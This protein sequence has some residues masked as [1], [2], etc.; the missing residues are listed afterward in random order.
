M[1]D[2]EML[3]IFIMIIALVLSAM[4]LNNNNKQSTSRHPAATVRRLASQ[5]EVEALLQAPS[6]SAF[7]ISHYLRCQLNASG[8]DGDYYLNRLCNIAKLHCGEVLAL[9][10]L[11]ERER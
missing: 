6:L 1:T 7:I 10:L 2:F 3:S 5:Q 4:S 11:G 8:D 9:N